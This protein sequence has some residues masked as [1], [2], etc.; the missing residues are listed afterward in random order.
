MPSKQAAYIFTERF[1]LRLRQRLHQHI[2]LGRAIS[3]NPRSAQRLVVRQRLHAARAGPVHEPLPM[4]KQFVV[5][6]K[7]AL[8]DAQYR[9][10]GGGIV[11][12][13]GGARHGNHGN[14]TVAGGLSENE[15]EKSEREDKSAELQKPQFLC[16]ISCCERS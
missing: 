15:E 6:G 14:G 3:S 13:N 12:G 4:H 11:N 1:R 2:E 9:V 10:G 16:Q 7:H 8:L 5:G